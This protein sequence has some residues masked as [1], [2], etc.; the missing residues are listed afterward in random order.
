M[1]LVILSVLA[2]MPAFPGIDSGGGDPLEASFIA[3]AHRVARILRSPELAWPDGNELSYRLS[4]VVRNTTVR[5]VNKP[6]VHNG[7][8]R[9]AVNY[10]SSKLIVVHRAAFLESDDSIIKM[11]F[12]LHEYLGILSSEYPKY[13]DDNYAISSRFVT[14]VRS[15]QDSV[16]L[17]QWP[18]PL[19]C[20]DQRLSP[21]TRS[22]VS[23]IMSKRLLLGLRTG[24]VFNLRFA[25]NE[26][27]TITAGIFKAD[28]TPGH[29]RPLQLF[30]CS[31]VELGTT[32]LKVYGD[33]WSPSGTYKHE[34]FILIPVDRR[35]IDGEPVVSLVDLRWGRWVPAEFVLR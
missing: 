6:I 11:A 5:I 17:T 33:R 29:R 14:S 12:V 16:V 4:G 8:A 13:R 21:G 32:Y 20:L 23:K 27:G 1:G 34:M 22:F 24:E 19:Q 10:P 2:P 28:G 30:E 7:E 9:A 15:L 18:P 3:E 25:S 26:L 31:D 35:L